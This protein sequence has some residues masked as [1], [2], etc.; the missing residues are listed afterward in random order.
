MFYIFHWICLC[1][2]QIFKCLLISN[3]TFIQ[4]PKGLGI[5]EDDDIYE[6]FDLSFENYEELFGMSQN[7]PG[8]LFEDEGIDSLFDVK[9]MPDSS[10][11]GGFVVDF[12]FLNKFFY[13]AI[14]HLLAFVDMRYLC[15]GK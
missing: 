12:F 4:L 14:M 2:T 6:D 7:Q 3:W 5:C 8:Q 15:L 1:I 9:N 13:S 10:G 11:Q